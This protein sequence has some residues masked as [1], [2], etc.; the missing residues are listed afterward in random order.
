LHLQGG[1]VEECLQHEHDTF[2]AAALSVPLAV[3]HAVLHD[4]AASLAFRAAFASAA[5]LSSAASSAWRGALRASS[6]VTQAK[7]GLRVE[8]W[9][10]CAL[11]RPP[12]PPVATSA[13]PGRSQS[14]P[15][16]AVDIGASE[17]ADGEGAQRPA[18]PAAVEVGIRD[19]ALAVMLDPPLAV[20]WQEADVERTTGI[21]VPA[22]PALD[23]VSGDLDPVLTVRFRMRIM[24]HP[25]A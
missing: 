7:H 9:P 4:V 22:V 20:L 18:W 25:T 10:R 13:A 15:Q 1:S 24:D 23:L 11:L 17:V 14:A 16:P 19:G 6:A 12:A 2:L 8:Y 21:G 3:L 5:H